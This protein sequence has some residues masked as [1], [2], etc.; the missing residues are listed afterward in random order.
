M[1][2]SRFTSDLCTGFET[3]LDPRRT[4]SSLRGL[5][6]FFN[7]H[8]TVVALNGPDEPLSFGCLIITKD[9]LFVFLFSELSMVGD[10]SL[11]DYY[12][13]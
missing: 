13:A 8:W 5:K 10:L 6:R 11:L 3:L 1:T 2:Q 9:L 12:V 4:V 7:D